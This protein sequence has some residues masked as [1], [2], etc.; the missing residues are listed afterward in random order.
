MPK[1]LLLSTAAMVAMMLSTPAFAVGPAAM[2]G[3]S[4]PVPVTGSGDAQGSSDQDQTGQ[5]D[6]SQNGG[7]ATG[8]ITNPTTPKPA[9]TDTPS[10]VSQPPGGGTPKG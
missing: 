2:P 7:S 9:H 5:S 6:A 8:P 10:H 1:K 3:T 4:A